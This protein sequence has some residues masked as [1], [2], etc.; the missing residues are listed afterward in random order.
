MNPDSCA[1]STIIFKEKKN[2]QTIGAR[3]LRNPDIW[4]WQPRNK[5][6]RENGNEKETM[7]IDESKKEDFEER[8]R[9]H[10]AEN[11]PKRKVEQNWGEAD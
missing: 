6:W 4:R 7:V 2:I 1:L 8:E 11:L 10:H 3:S 5:I 9:C